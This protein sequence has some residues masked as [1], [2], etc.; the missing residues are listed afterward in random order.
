MSDT[1][2]EAGEP[3]LPFFCTYRLW[4]KDL[5][6]IVDYD[7][8]ANGSQ[9]AVAFDLQTEKETLR[10]LY[11]EQ[12]DFFVPRAHWKNVKLPA[13]TSNPDTISKAFSELMD[14][15]EARAQI[16]DCFKTLVAA[17]QFEPLNAVHIDTLLTVYI[18]GLE[19][20]IAIAE[21]TVSNK[22]EFLFSFETKTEYD[23]LA[24]QKRFIIGA[25]WF[26]GHVV[27]YIFD[28][29]HA[30]LCLFDTKREDRQFRLR[31]IAAAWRCQLRVCGVEEASIDV[32]AA[33][34][35]E[36]PQNIHCGYLAVSL[37]HYCIRG[38]VGVHAEDLVMRPLVADNSSRARAANAR[39]LR[40]T[41]PLRD[42]LLPDTTSTPE[43]AILLVRRI[44]I[45]TL[46]HELSLRAVPGNWCGRSQAPVLIDDAHWAE[47]TTL[48][49]K[50]QQQVEYEAT[51][52]IF[53]GF[54]P[55]YIEGGREPFM[56][57]DRGIF[58]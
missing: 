50:D 37:I 40:W 47:F 25:I 15:V 21:C 4:R 8:N 20:I 3:T 54:V 6:G 26:Q 30:T 23:R 9:Q 33:P 18:K 34:C 43:P 32:F 10:Q 12:P 49:D 11:Q 14:T 24:R 16:G 13:S 1:R 22:F 45:T 51:R 27:G 41:L 39:R 29:A 42:W 2:E 48:L 57:P 28:T 58:P 52:S 31:T 36:Q 44:I 17:F 19:D 5:L 35:T 7:V 53:G 38:L 56:D 55:M 46:L